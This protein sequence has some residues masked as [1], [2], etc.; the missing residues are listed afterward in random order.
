VSA[1]IVELTGLGRKFGDRAVLSNLDLSVAAGE[2][3]A[4]VGASG[5]GK[6]TLLHVMGA[7]DS[8]FTGEVKLFGQSLKGLG[9]DAL[10]SLRT[11]TVGFVFQSFHLLE[12]L[13]VVENVKLPLWLLE[14]GPDDE[15]A[16]QRALDALSAVGLRD[17]A[18]D[19]IGPLSG[20]E[21]QRIAIARA[22]VHAPKL[23]LADEPTGNLDA[24]TGASILGLFDQARK[25]VDC[26]VIVVTHDPRVAPRADRVLALREGRLV[27]A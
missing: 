3:V 17:R 18:N 16:E 23:I 5:S 14:D 8:A 27:P 22:M 21:R 13:R 6:T 15:V 10:S 25:Q 19:A 12:H 24:E 20:G 11:R 4:I 26:G 1:P 2:L 7:L 9:D